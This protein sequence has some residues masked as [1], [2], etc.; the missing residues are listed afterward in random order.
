[1]RLLLFDPSSGA[2]GDMIMASLLDLGADPDAVRKAVEAVGCG[3]D[4]SLSL[5]HI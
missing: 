1:M 3:L 2:S 5:I 4:I